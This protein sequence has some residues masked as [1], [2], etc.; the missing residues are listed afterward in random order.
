MR[1]EN[2]SIQKLTFLCQFGCE[3]VYYNNKCYKNAN[4]KIK[5]IVQIAFQGSTYW[6]LY[7]LTQS[8]FG[9]KVRTDNGE[10]LLHLLDR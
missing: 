5:M 3:D 9:V 1:E 2:N 6:K 8:H 10:E 4:W 7:F